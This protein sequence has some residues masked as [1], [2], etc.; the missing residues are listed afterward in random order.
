MEC[1]KSVTQFYTAIKNE[2]SAHFDGHSRQKALS[3]KLADF[4]LLSLPLALEFYIPLQHSAEHTLH[5][6]VK[7]CL[8]ESSSEPSGE[9]LHAGLH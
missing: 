4:D 9:S 2:A 1:F 5:L 6:H 8:T 3:C 7:A